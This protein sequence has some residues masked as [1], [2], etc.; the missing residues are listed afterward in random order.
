MSHTLVYNDR[1][2]AS[3]PQKVSIILY[4]SW[5]ALSFQSSE[6]VQ[7]A[8][9]H[10]TASRVVPKKTKSR[11]R[12]LVQ[13][14]QGNGFDVDLSSSVGDPYEARARCLEAKQESRIV[15]RAL[16][17]LCH[18]R[19]KDHRSRLPTF[20]WDFKFFESGFRSFGEYVYSLRKQGKTSK[21]MM[22][23]RFVLRDELRLIR[24]VQETLFSKEQWENIETWIYGKEYEKPIS[25]ESQRHVHFVEKVLESMLGANELYI[26][27]WVD[28]KDSEKILE[29]G[30]AHV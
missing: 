8:L 13:F 30:R 18:H 1:V 25:K 6:G 27:S 3:K 14:F 19:G 20:Q 7:H 24:S 10:L 26:G 2:H 17:H 11:V 5:R 29:I 21:H 28:P 22:V 16:I 9:H 23:S 15:M 4:G 12:K